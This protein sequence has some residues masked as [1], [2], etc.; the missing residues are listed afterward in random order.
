MRR[1]EGGKVVG[2]EE[3]CEASS[4]ATG[5]LCAALMGAGRKRQETAQQRASG[6]CG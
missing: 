6:A 4:V 5:A 3:D 1:F 2:L